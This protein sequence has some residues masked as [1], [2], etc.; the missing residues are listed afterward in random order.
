MSATILSGREVAAAVRA[1][2][3]DR[4]AALADRGK[5]VGLATILVGDDPASHVYVGH[6]HKA[7]TAAGMLSF[8]EHLPASAG[9]GEVEARIA[10][11]NADPA[12][13]GMI[14]QLPLPAGLDGNRAVEAIDPAK[15][16]DGLHP[17]SLGL[18]V[19][20][21]PG[22]RPATPSGVMR[23]LSHYGIPTAGRTA[24][25]VGRSFLVGRP[26][27][28]MLGARGADATVIQAHS[29]TPDLAAVTRQADILI[30]A[31]G[32]PRLIGAGHVKPGA[33][34]IDVGMNRLE[35]GLVGD[36]DFDAVAEVASAI[37]PVPGGVGPMTVATLLANTVAA[38]E[39]RMISGT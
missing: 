1:E 25:V 13:D 16:A 28:L 11:F 36:V 19:L 21:R 31:V 15:D 4:V 9:Q 34:V 37:T 7:A 20:D 38:A 23:I 33:V 5:T 18:L 26:L 8:D 3:T 12:V 32:V 6:K 24:V 35:E 10:A 2:V 39:R 22:P 27:A 17:H 29:R 30:A 14:V